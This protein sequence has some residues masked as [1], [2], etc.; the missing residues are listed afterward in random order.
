MLGVEH[1][2]A[3]WPRPGLRPL[4]SSVQRAEARE[5]R[6]RGR[7]RGQQLLGSR[8]HWVEAVD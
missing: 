1:G 6:H 2:P 3:P 7:R 8:Q 4:T 5:P